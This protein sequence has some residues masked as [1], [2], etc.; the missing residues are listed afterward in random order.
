M[1]MA[2]RVRVGVVGTSWFADGF[3]LPNL[4]SHPQA[5]VAAICGRNRERADELATKY[6]IPNVFTDYQAMIGSGMLDALVVITPDAM[7]YP[8]AMAA[9][10]AGLHV[11][12]EKALALTAAQAREMYERAEARGVKHMVLFTW[13]WAPH[14]RYLHQLIEQGFVGRCYH[15]HFRYESGYGR[16]ASYGWRFD[17]Q[18]GT[19][20]LGDLGSHMIDMARWCI[21][22]IVQVSGHLAT[23]VERPGPDGQTLDAANDS[24]LLAVELAGGAHASIHVSAVAHLG[25]RDLDGK[26]ALYGE[27]GSLELD[28]SF[29]GAE[30]R[31]LRQGETQWQRLPVPDDLWSGADRSAAFIDQVFGLFQTQPI[32]DRLFV[33]SILDDRPVTPSFYDGWTAQEVIDAAIASHEQRRWIAIG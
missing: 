22:D 30:L 7:H 16:D 11:L 9:L 4:V 1:S 19:G 14:F 2:D 20:L 26:L 28:F 27:A 15:G 23:F 3:H 25:E 10:D 5:V 17:R 31:G 8:I 12:C 13:R 29:A 21:G 33:D 18:Q 32:G 24:A 6:A